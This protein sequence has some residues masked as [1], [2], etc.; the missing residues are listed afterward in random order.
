W[1]IPYQAGKLEVVASDQNG[2][3]TARYAVTTSGRPHAI[4]ILSAEKSP[5]GDIAQIV[6]QVKDEKRSTRDVVRRRDHRAALRPATLLGMEAGNNQDMTDYTDNKH[7]GVPRPMV[8]YLR[9]EDKNA[10]VKVRLT[11]P[12][13]QPAETGFPIKKGEN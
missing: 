11:S 7:R 10:Q 8:I 3:E 2:R 6:L 1:D 9:L 4:D 12:W 5:E 13:L